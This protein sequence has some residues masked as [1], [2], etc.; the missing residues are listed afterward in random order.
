VR[1]ASEFP[2]VGI[3]LDSSLVLQVPATP[4]VIRRR[5]RLTTS[6]DDMVTSLARQGSNFGLPIALQLA[7][8]MKGGIG[9]ARVRLWSCLRRRECWQG[10]N[11]RWLCRC[12]VIIVVERVSVLVG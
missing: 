10:C 3:V 5:P 2:E 11:M 7:L 1:A 9:L 4:G 6:V 12:C 8:L